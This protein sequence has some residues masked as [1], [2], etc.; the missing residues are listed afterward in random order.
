MPNTGV[1]GGSIQ[2]LRFDNNPVR[3]AERARLT[4]GP[5]ARD[6]RFPEPKPEEMTR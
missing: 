4:I 3:D 5:H 1:A 6:L 2:N